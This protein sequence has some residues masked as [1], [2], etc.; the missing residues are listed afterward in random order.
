MAS[1]ADY[2]LQQADAAFQRK[3]QLYDQILQSI[4]QEELKTPAIKKAELELLAREETRL[5]SMEEDLRKAQREQIK[6][7]TELLKVVSQGQGDIAQANIRFN[8]AVKT[9]SIRSATELAIERSKQERLIDEKTAAD[10]AKAA[11]LK[12]SAIT[13]AGSF[14]TGTFA[15]GLT[16]TQ[17]QGW[18]VPRFL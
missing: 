5:R 8:E 16:A 12:G 7:D 2:F 14:G 9:A 18:Q 3:Q 17:T 11:A 13:S 4:L 15:P 6:S 1:Y 10:K